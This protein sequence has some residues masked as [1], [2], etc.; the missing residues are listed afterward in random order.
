MESKHICYVLLLTGFVV[1]H[2]ELLAQEKSHYTLPDDAGAAWAE[3][4]KVHQLLRPPD[5]WRTNPPKAEQIAAFQK[6]VR[7]T[8]TSFAGK[9]REFIERF[10]TNENVAD[11]RI[12]VVHAL[13][14]A[15]AA[16][17]TDAEKQIA[18]FV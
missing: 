16:G 3:V 12:T 10:P 13:S 2:P 1:I 17:D 8:A 9:A 4:E 7:Q 14:H 11:A 5:E 18:A 15:V 6:Q